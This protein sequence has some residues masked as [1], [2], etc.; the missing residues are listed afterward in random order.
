[1]GLPTTVCYILLA[2]TVAPSLA[3]M[4]ALPIAA[5]LFIFYFGMLCMV[6]PPVGFA[7]YAGAAIAN[8][9]PM[10]TGFMAWKLALAGFI[11]PTVFIYNLPLPIFGTLRK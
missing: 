3:K 5:H 2:A 11:L 4:A 9:E 6:T 8:A 1:M 10:K 7:F